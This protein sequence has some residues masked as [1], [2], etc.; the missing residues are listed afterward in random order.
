MKQ[1]AFIKRSNGSHWVGDGF[2]V[3][4]IFSY[5][6]IAEE[7]SPFLLM[8]YAGPANFPATT[9]KLGVGQHPH[10]GFETVT[11]VYEG[12]VSHNDSSGGGGTIGPGDVQWMT[13]A[14]GL[15]HEEYHSPE[16]ARTGGAFEM[17]QLWVNLP[18]RDKMA[19]P[20]YQGI[21]ADQIPDVTLPDGA[22]QARIIAGS[23]AGREGPAHTFT[24]MNVWDLRLNAGHRLAFEL[25]E[26]HTTA[27]FVL[28]GTIRLGDHHTV[29]TAELAVMER[30]GSQLAFNVEEDT[31]LLLLN[32]APLNEPVV[33]HGPFVMN[34]RE[35]IAQAI[36][37]FNS[38]RFGQIG[39]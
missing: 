34:T 8:D 27:L 3:R 5:S 36:N 21:T 38:G 29:R 28:K 35:E 23:Y 4:S 33:G 11:I 20:G 12:G 30:A 32:G 26:Q 6:D 31:T 13:A 16:F 1:L 10:R 25:P 22:G 19:A 18:A 17:V 14:S 7:M 2:P 39:H 9:Q 37:D 24:P 15:I